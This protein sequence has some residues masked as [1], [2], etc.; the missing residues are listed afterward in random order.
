MEIAERVRGAARRLGTI[1]FWIAVLV[2]AAVLG[3]TPPMRALDAAIAAHRTPLVV[4]TAAVLVVGFILFMGSV[5]DL[6]ISSGDPLQP[7]AAETG[8]SRRF[9]RG[10][11]TR[12]RGTSAGTQAHDAFTLAALKDAWR[13]G[14]WLRQPVWRRRTIVTAGGLMTGFGI[15]ALLFVIGPPYVRIIVG[16]ALLYALVRTSWAFAHA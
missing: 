1:V 12:F 5:L 6:M 16:A 10:A 4:G 3:E 15:F 2:V 11:V 8:R 9:R 7:G 14:A 13:S